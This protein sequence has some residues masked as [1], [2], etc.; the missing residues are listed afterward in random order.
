[1]NTAKI[2][3]QLW[4]NNIFFNFLVTSLTYLTKAGESHSC[5]ICEH[6]QRLTLSIVWI[7][8]YLV[9]EYMN[10]WDEHTWTKEDW[11]SLSPH[12]MLS[13]EV[14]ESTCG[15]LSW[16]IPTEIAKDTW[17]I[18]I[19]VCLSAQLFKTESWI[20]QDSWQFEKKNYP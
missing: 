15:E 6:L 18:F 9:L 5:E 11:T 10:Y 2:Y 4:K 17:H 3:K 20:Y 13:D 14:L 1:M 7:L 8:P 19:W 12:F 16:A